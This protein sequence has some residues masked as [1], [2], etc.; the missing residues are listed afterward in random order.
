[1]T[2]K[3][4]DKY[5]TFSPCE[6]TFLVARH[7]LWLLLRHKVCKVPN[8][9]PNE[10]ALRPSIVKRPK[11]FPHEIVLE[12]LR[13]ADGGEGVESGHSVRPVLGHLKNEVKNFN[14]N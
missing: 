13:E 9:L 12:L 7:P 4:Q 14:K 3:I 10:P 1:M 5:Q 2:G 11:V 6:N 8:H